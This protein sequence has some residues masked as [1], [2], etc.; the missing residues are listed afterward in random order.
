ME[1]RVTFA[2]RK[3][4]HIKRTTLRTMTNNNKGRERERR[5]PR[6][7]NAPIYDFA[8]LIIFY[9]SIP[10]CSFLLL[11]LCSHSFL[12][13]CTY[14]PVLLLCSPPTRFTT[15]SPPTSLPAHPTTRGTSVRTL[16][17][18]L[19]LHLLAYLHTYTSLLPPLPCTRLFLK[20]LPPLTPFPPPPSPSSSPS[21]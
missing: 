13:T 11:L 3:P 16:D 21:P 1:G 5:C 9:C 14:T 20:S 4:V 18:L 7:N 10:G 8:I 12:Y 17:L 19:L 15:Y 6:A 2:E